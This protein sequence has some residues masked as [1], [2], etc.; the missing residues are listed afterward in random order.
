MDKLLK[1]DQKD[2]CCPGQRA[3]HV[4]PKSRVSNCQGYDHNKAP[5]VCVEGGNNSGTHGKLHMATDKNTED[6]VYGIY[7]H[8]PSANKEPSSMASAIEASA[9]AMSKEFG[10]DKTCI[11]RELDKFY[12]KLCPNGVVLK[13]RNGK[14]IEKDRE[15]KEG[16]RK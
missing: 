15:V 3:H 4:I 13:D 7:E 12:R 11:K 6:M 9:Q 10:C 5:T 16:G 8:S 1:L 14:V 2:G